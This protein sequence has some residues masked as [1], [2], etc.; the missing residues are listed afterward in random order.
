MVKSLLVA[1]ADRTAMVQ[2]AALMAQFDNLFVVRLVGVVTIGHPL[3]VVIEFCEH[4]A[5][6]QV[7]PS[8]QPLSPRRHQV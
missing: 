4:G 5:L 2:E 7:L 8:Q 3:L 1:D 6:N